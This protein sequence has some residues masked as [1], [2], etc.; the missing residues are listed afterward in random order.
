MTTVESLGGL[1]GFE[2]SVQAVV[3][4]TF[5]QGFRVLVKGLVGPR[6]CFGVGGS[7]LAA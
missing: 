2:K 1:E 5:D 6:S 7:R 4:P 3:I